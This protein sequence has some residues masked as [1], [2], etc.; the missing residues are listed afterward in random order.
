M[1][2]FDEWKIG[3]ERKRKV[4]LDEAFNVKNVQKNVQQSSP[5]EI[6]INMRLS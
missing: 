3:E 1:K 6:W 5:S 2:K 4:K